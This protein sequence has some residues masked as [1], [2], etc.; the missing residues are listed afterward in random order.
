M[1]SPAQHP[2]R[3]PGPPGAWGAPP[4]RTSWLAPLLVLGSAGLVA[5]LAIGF[6]LWWFAIRED[7]PGLQQAQGGVGTAVRE[8]NLEFTV[9][10]VERGT[11]E[12]GD[13]NE[14]FGAWTVVRV[15]VRNVGADPRDLELEHQELYDA[16]GWDFT[17]DEN[18]AGD[19][20]ESSR[21]LLTLNPGDEEQVVLVVD[22]LADEPIVSVE[23][24]EEEDSRGVLVPLD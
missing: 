1:T 9:T 6:A 15:T 19:M 8:G 16:R 3:P 17:H 2:Q 14:P 20:G 11:G 18:A 12:A 22:G 5:V 21:T 23:F 7:L 4:K 24:H 13:D 10:E